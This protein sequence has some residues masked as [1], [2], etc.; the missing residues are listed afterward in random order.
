ME[1]IREMFKQSVDDGI[2]YTEA[3]M[4]FYNKL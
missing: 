4:M 1:Y 2:M 3:R